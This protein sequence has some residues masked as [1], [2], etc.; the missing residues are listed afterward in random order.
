ML[1]N[2]YQI[3]LRQ[4][5]ERVQRRGKAYNLRYYQIQADEVSDPGLVSF[6][7]YQTWKFI[8]EVKIACGVSYAHEILPLRAFYFPTYQD[9]LR[10]RKKYGVN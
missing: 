2:E 10:L 6:R 5:I 7:L 8:D 4:L 3:A 9:I 1:L